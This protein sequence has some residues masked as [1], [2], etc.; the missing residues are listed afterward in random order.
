MS[1]AHDQSFMSDWALES[2]AVP[3]SHIKKTQ[4]LECS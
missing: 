3:W 4:G 1:S 2:K